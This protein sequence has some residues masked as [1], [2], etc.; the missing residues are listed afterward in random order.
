M[1]FCFGHFVLFL[2]HILIQGLI[3][4]V[5]LV[6]CGFCQ[7]DAKQRAQELAAKLA[8]SAELE[9][10]KHNSESAVRIYAC[11]NYLIGP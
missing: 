8:V 11:P 6:D 2:P 7:A 1:Q 10:Q 5:S 3:L 4:F 9:E